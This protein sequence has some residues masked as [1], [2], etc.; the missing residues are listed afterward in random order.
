MGCHGDFGPRRLGWEQGDGD[1][2]WE[3]YG[4]EQAGMRRV[5]VKLAVSGGVRELSNKEQGWMSC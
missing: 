1:V 2:R 3:T 5:T 4:E